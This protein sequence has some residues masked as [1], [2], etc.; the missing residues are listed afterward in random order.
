VKEGAAINSSIVLTDQTV[1]EAL[2]IGVRPIDV[3]HILATLC[4][5][6][7]EVIDVGL[8]TWLAYKAALPPRA[9]H[10]KL[11][12]KID[13]SLRALDRVYQLGFDSI[14]VTYAHQ[15]GAGL[16]AG[17]CM[18]LAKARRLGIDTS[19]YLENA[20]LLSP[21]EIL[22]FGPMLERVGLATLVYSD[23]DSRLDPFAVLHALRSLQ[24]LP[25][26]VEFHAHN[27]LGLATANTL[28]AMQ[29]G[30]SRLATAVAGVGTNGH[31][32]MEEVL[33]AGKHLLR[34]ETDFT[35]RLA[36]VCA[37]IMAC[38]D[39]AVPVDKAIVGRDIFAHESG[40][41][42]DGVTKNPQI[43]EIFQPEEVGLERRLVIGKHS[44]TASL[45]SKFTEWGISLAEPIARH[46]LTEVRSLAIEQKGP[47]TD[48]QLRQLYAETVMA[49]TVN[50]MCLEA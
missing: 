18:L 31:A 45:R 40:I 16:S 50:D 28:G 24:T 9:I 8:D 38:L 7:V 44:G 30:V 36:A 1:N 20:P 6:P 34:T 15:P 43:Y 35:P 19:L 13:G 21:D 33:L 11:R 26:P 42:V 48:G 5:L 3:Y 2:R 22:S 29:A 27:S 10:N 46:L 32:A 37:K 14:L 23:K 12:V 17:L 25:C 4:E 47:L 41:H 39:V 49:D